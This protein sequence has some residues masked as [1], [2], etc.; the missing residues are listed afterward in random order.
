V[1]QLLEFRPRQRVTIFLMQGE[2]LH[3]VTGH[4]EGDKEHFAGVFHSMNVEELH[5]SVEPRQRV[6]RSIIRWE[7]QLM[8]VA[9][10]RGDS[11]VVRLSRRV[12][13]RCQLV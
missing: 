11:I 7:Q 9:G 1:H 6:F 2:P 4:I 12:A 8:A 3:I 10:R 5:T 13:I